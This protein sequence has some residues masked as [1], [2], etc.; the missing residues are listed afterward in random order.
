MERN[1]E[2]GRGPLSEVKIGHMIVNLFRPESRPGHLKVLDKLGQT[3]SV[4]SMSFPRTSSLLRWASE[5]NKTRSKIYSEFARIRH[6]AT[7]SSKGTISED[8][9]DTKT[10]INEDLETFR[11]RRKTD[12]KRRQ[13]VRTDY[14]S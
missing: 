11:R 6:V 13:G 10:N 9:D 7:S 2:L 5:I 1:L 4:S 12:W 3:L 14:T 8:G